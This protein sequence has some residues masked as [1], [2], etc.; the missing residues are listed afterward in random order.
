MN[1]GNKRRCYYFIIYVESCANSLK[2]S[3]LKSQVYY[4]DLRN[5]YYCVQGRW[6]VGTYDFFRTDTYTLAYNY[7]VVGNNRKQSPRT[8]PV[9]FITNSCFS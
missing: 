8:A 1:E 7:F 3:M 5:L 6:L 9:H 2:Y 4:L